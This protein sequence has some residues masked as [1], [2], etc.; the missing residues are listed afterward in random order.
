[1]KR[2]VFEVVKIKSGDMALIIR[3]DKISYKVEIVNKN[4]KRKEM[5]KINENDIDE[6]IVIKQNKIKYNE[7]T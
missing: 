1:M 7:I 5:T 4:A 2:K 3:I 6:V